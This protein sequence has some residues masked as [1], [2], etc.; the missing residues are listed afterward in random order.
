[1]ATFWINK[2]NKKIIKWKDDK[3]TDKSIKKV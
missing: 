2:I 3:N 1:M